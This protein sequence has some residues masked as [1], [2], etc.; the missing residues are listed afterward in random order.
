MYLR[1]KRKKMVVFLQVG[2]VDSVGNVK[3]AL[4]EYI[5]EEAASQRL[6]WR[7]TLLQDEQRLSDLGIQDDDELGLAL[8]TPTGEWETLEIARYDAPDGDAE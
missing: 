3:E 6:Y 7:D 1:I 2:P 8:K 4:H 5:Q